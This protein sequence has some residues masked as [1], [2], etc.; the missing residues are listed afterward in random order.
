MTI[1]ERG[2]GI[3]RHLTWFWRRLHVANDEC[4]GEDIGVHKEGAI[5]SKMLFAVTA[6]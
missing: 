4:T 5:L 1:G 3:R 6:S 2:S